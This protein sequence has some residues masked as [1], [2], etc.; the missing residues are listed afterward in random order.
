MSCDVPR[1]GDHVAEVGNGVHEKCLMVHK[2]TWA[3]GARH[4]TG[5]VM[6]SKMTSHFTQAG[7]NFKCF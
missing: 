5:L 6:T 4:L 7:S 2:R 3:K 1:C